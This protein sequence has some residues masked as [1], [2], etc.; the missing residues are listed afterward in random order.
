MIRLFAYGMYIRE[1]V[2]PYC[3]GIKQR[4]DQLPLVLMVSCWLVAVMIRVYGYGIEKVDSA[5]KY[6]KGTPIRYG[7]LSSVLMVSCWLVAVMTR[8]F[9][10]GILTPSNMKCCV[11]I[12]IGFDQLPSAL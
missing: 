1:H 9:A 2:T 8:L 4:F 5:A 6:C 7:Q 11:N 10:Y 12:A 3:K